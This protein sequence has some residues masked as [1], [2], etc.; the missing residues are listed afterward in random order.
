MT[1]KYEY[2][3]PVPGT[4]VQDCSN[5]LLTSVNSSCAHP[6]PP[7]LTPDMGNS[8]ILGHFSYQMFRGGDEGGGQ[9]P[10]LSDPPHSTLHQFSLFIS[11]AF[12]SN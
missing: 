4:F 11:C 7:G 12:I 9:M 5:R 6:L 3:C 2:Y 8:E 1:E 10:C